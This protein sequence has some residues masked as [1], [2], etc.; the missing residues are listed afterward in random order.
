MLLN[1]SLS[2]KSYILSLMSAPFLILSMIT[3]VGILVSLESNFST[4]PLGREKSVNS[5]ELMMNSYFASF[6]KNLSKQYLRSFMNLISL[7]PYKTQKYFYL[8]LPSQVVVQGYS[9]LGIFIKELRI[10]HGNDY[11]F[12]ILPITLACQHL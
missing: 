6:L 4:S 11:I 12:S 5:S 8:R 10:K 3:E 1:L 2:V 7:L 9:K